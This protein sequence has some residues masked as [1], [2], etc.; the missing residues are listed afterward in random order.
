[1]APPIPSGFPLSLVAGTTWKF[2]AG[3][4]DFPP[5]DGWAVTFQLVGRASG[6]LASTPRPTTAD[7]LV[8]IDTTASAAFLAGAYHWTAIATLAGESYVAASGTV[9]ITASPT[10]T[11]LSDARSFA[12]LTLE[13]VEAE[14]G[15]RFGTNSSPLGAAH[16]S[17]TIGGRNITKISIADLQVMRARLIGEVEK[18]RNGGSLPPFEVEFGRPALGN[19]PNWRRGNY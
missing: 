2:T 19:W 3:F 11:A 1:M 15:A 18:E 6:A 13:K 14:I 17:Y 5:V 12:A 9:D 7:Y 10:L 8:T 16:E 4:T